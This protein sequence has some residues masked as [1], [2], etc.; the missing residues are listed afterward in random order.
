[1]RVAN[2]VR[3]GS[4]LYHNN[5]QYISKPYNKKDCEKKHSHDRTTK[6]TNRQNESLRGLRL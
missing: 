5:K 4:E 2:A 3:M 1:M 6:N